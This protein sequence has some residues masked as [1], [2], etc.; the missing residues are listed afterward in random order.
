MSTVFSQI[1]RDKSSALRRVDRLTTDEFKYLAPR[2]HPTEPTR[3]LTLSSKFRNLPKC[4]TMSLRQGAAATVLIDGGKREKC[5][6]WRRDGK[7]VV[8]IGEASGDPQVFS[9]EIAT[10]ELR[11]LTQMPG[12][13]VAVDCSPYGDRIVV[14]VENGGKYGIKVVDQ[15]DDRVLPVLSSQDPITSISWSR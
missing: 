8:F 4:H 12:K 3:L 7:V 5:P 9:F 10:R 6:A 14:V 15:K 2:M 1:A 13:K 11:Q